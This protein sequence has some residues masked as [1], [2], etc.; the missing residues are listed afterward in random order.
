MQN[1]RL[2]FTLKLRLRLKL[3]LGSAAHYVLTLGPLCHVGALLGGESLQSNRAF[4]PG[5]QP[6]KVGLAATGVGL[7]DGH[8]HAARG[9]TALVLI[10]S[11]YRVPLHA[12]S[13]NVVDCLPVL[14]LAELQSQRIHVFVIK[15][16]LF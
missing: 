12:G 10:G 3:R 11:S 13:F 7:T 8:G 6:G 4:G 16:N 2:D 14:L 5:A 9:I 1:L 15:H